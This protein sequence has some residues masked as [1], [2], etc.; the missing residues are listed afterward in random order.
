MQSVALS[1]PSC[2]TLHH[3]ICYRSWFC[4][5]LYINWG[6]RSSFTSNELMNKFSLPF[7]SV[8]LQWDNSVKRQGK[9]EH[10]HILYLKYN[11]RCSIPKQLRQKN[12]GLWRG[13]KEKKAFTLWQS[14]PGIISWIYTKGPSF[15]LIPPT[16]FKPRLVPL[17]TEII[18]NALSLETQ[19][20]RKTEL[21]QRTR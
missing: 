3:A 4:T 5:L 9:E 7:N 11:C 19:R 16:I 13:R 18:W 2:I 14:P 17:Q 12:T 6:I 21:L 8:T 15:L 20:E 1:H 10:K